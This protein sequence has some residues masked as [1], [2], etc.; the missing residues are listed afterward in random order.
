VLED[1]NRLIVPPGSGQRL[2]EFELGGDI[3]RRQLHRPAISP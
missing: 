2:S 3:I 1:G